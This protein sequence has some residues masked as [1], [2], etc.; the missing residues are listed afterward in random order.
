MRAL[1]SELPQPGCR[2]SWPVSLPDL[3][4]GGAALEPGSSV[5]DLPNVNWW[6]STDIRVRT[7]LVSRLW[8][9][10]RPGLTEEGDRRVLPKA[11]ARNPDRVMGMTVPFLSYTVNHV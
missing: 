8:R 6:G 11:I 1:R 9:I 7:G 3:R 5:R 10:A 4:P 2:P